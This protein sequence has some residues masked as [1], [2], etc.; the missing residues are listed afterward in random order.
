MKD[1]NEKAFF[2]LTYG[3][4]VIG[5]KNGEEQSACIVNTLTQVTAVP[6]RLAVTINKE[7]YTAELIQASGRFTATALDQR[8][9][10]PYIGRFG[11][12]TG[13]DFDKFDGIAHWKDQAGVPFP[14]D[15]VCARF[16]VKVEQT[17]DLG[18]HLMFIGT[19]EEA[20]MLS[21]AEPL[22]YTFYRDVIKGSTPKNAP[23]YHAE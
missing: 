9:D 13:R 12:R 19:A 8:A 20:E 22:T 2:K 16:S 21:D 10:F 6:P 5:A 15:A 3:L 4:Y 11:F 14:M 1:M 17:V 7:G 23:S 18:T